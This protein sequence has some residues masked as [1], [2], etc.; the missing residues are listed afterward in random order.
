MSTFFNTSDSSLDATFYPKSVSK[1]DGT[2]TTSRKSTHMSRNSLKFQESQ[3]TACN[4][5]APAGSFSFAFEPQADRGLLL[6][7]SCSALLQIFDGLNVNLKRS[8]YVRLS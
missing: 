2:A 6:R 4:A 7:R 3:N 5:R 1:K 8:D